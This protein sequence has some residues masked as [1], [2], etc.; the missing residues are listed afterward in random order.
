MQAMTGSR[1]A[2]RR[3]L[4][5]ED[6]RGGEELQGVV[7]G[8]GDMLGVQEGVDKGVNSD[9]PPNPARCGKRG[10]GIRRPRGRRGQ[11]YQNLQIDVSREGRTYTL[12]I[13]R[14]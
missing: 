11:Q 9:A 3:G 8:A 10:V 6:D 1:G 12:P 2:G 7:S 4:N 14:V 5:P 13:P